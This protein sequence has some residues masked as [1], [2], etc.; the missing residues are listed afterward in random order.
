MKQPVLKNIAVCAG[1]SMEEDGNAT[2]STC[3][4][5][6]RSGDLTL[7]TIVSKHRV[8]DAPK[9]AAALAD[10]QYVAVESAS[11]YALVCQCQ[12]Q[13]V[14]SHLDMYTMTVGHSLHIGMWKLEFQRG[15]HYILVGPAVGE[16]PNA[17]LL[18][19][20][21]RVEHLRHDRDPIYVTPGWSNPLH[22]RAPS[23]NAQDPRKIGMPLDPHRAALRVVNVFDILDDWSLSDLL[24]ESRYIALQGDWRRLGAKLSLE[25]AHRRQGFWLRR[26]PHVVGVFLGNAQRWGEYTFVGPSGGVGADT[27][28]VPETP[29]PELLA[30]L[31]TDLHYTQILAEKCLG[32]NCRANDE[33]GGEE[34][35]WPPQQEQPRHGG[36]LWG[37]YLYDLFAY[38]ICWRSEEWAATRER[39]TDTRSVDEWS[40]RRADRVVN[41]TT[42][43]SSSSV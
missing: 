21:T 5:S 6:T 36:G 18:D 9:L 23:S 27:T 2:T 25:P 14:A 1:A 12:L 42:S 8:N 39:D 20:M 33:E 29:L 15:R 31:K 32:A 37:S 34:E 3:A 40:H 26:Y 41:N 22:Q 28:P 16:Q 19:I 38:Y 24:R 30:L 11:C 43:S 7:V 4:T 13:E 10:S 17:P 35:G